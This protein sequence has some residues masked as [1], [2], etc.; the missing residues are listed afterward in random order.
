VGPVHFVVLN[1]NESAYSG[2]DGYDPV[3]VAS[4]QQTWASGVIAFSDCPWVVVVGH[5]PP[6]TSDTLHTPGLADVRWLDSEPI[7]LGLFGHAHN[8]ERLESN[9]KTYM[10]CGASGHSLR[11]FG[12]P[13]AESKFRDS[14]QYGAILV[15]VDKDQLVAK[16]YHVDG[17]LV[18]SHTSAAPIR[19]LTTCYTT[20]SVRTLEVTPSF[21]E[22]EIGQ[23]Y[24]YRAYATYEDGTRADVTDDSTVWA[25]EEG[26]IAT[27][28]AGKAYGV[29]LG[30]TTISATH[31]G[32]T[33]EAG[34]SVKAQCVDIRRDWLWC[35]ER[36][37]SME[38]TANGKRILTHL[39]EAM[40]GCTQRMQDTDTSGVTSF[41]GDYDL[42]TADAYIN[43]P[44]DSDKSQT[45]RE[46]ESLRGTDDSDISGGLDLCYEQLLDAD[47][48]N[49]EDR[50]VVVLI[51]DGPARVTDPGGDGT[52][53]TAMAAAKVSADRIKTLPGAILV[54]IGYNVDTTYTQLVT[55]L[56]TPGYYFDVRDIDE[57]RNTVEQMPSIIC[58]FGDN[59]YNYYY[60]CV[61]PQLDYTGFINWDVTN[62]VVDLCGEGTNGIELYNQFPGNGLYI[63]MV[64]TNSNNSIGNKQ[65][66]GHMT[67]K[68]SYNF[69]AGKRYKFSIDVSG[70][71]RQENEYPMSI[72]CL[73]GSLLNVK[74]TKGPK[75]QADNFS[76]FSWEFD[77]TSTVS[78]SIQLIMERTGQDPVSVV[79]L[80][81]KD[82]KLENLTDTT[83]MLL[84][85]FDGEN[86]CV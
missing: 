67:S 35:V 18:D 30:T 16:Y 71:G 5:S 6:Y 39:A 77:V 31:R 38:Q 82:V 19:G 8:Y 25:I 34:L 47:V 73:I 23:S 12:T 65:R 1:A 63:D 51:V 80:F 78:E 13:L 2:Y 40:V 14:S 53:E 7:S 17:S 37:A 52:M 83:I 59:P 11:G 85:S 28:T 4:A 20:K 76:T 49:S 75:S 3:A 41:A 46:F 62:G 21:A 72:H 36:S 56:A 29:N 57:L 69:E 44:L 54:V 10:V 50:G 79:G 86:A 58:E 42:Q 24:Q 22:L 81:I 64:G 55:D 43:H 33:A 60:A 9:G 45:V 61:S 15:E 26:T 70:T 32:I 66:E 68:V 48:H 27:M 84:D 74:A